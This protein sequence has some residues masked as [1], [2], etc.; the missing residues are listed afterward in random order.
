M[1]LDTIAA[2]E[3]AL[4]LG[5]FF[6]LLALLA[7]AESLAPRRR[8]LFA[9]R[10]RWPAN[11]AI[12]AIDTLAL[13]FL[14]P[15]LAVGAAFWAEMN[16]IGALEYLPW[17]SWAEILL[18]ILLLDALVYAQHVAFHH[19]PVLWRIHRMHHADRDI[20]VTTALRFH[21]IEIL[22][23]M[24][25]KIAFVVVLGAPVAAVVCFEILLNGMAMF[26]HANLSLPPKADAWLRLFVVTPDMHRVHHSTERSEHDR[27]FGFALS[28]WDR[29][30]ATYKAQP[31]L[32]HDGMNIGL[33]AWQDARPCRLGWSLLLPFRR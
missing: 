1:S 14:L 21:P 27:N 13:R 24:L 26:N 7:A 15:I 29:I 25:L 22:L 30:F 8:R 18:A 19:I 11:F 31:H 32:G 9:R 3:G 5:A 23:S 2:H 17:P 4:R 28:C 6:A 33:A 20:D 12:A 16:Q 10:R